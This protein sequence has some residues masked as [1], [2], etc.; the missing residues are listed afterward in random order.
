[1]T[2]TADTRI[3]SAA[4]FHKQGYVRPHAKPFTI[5]STDREIHLAAREN[6]NWLPGFGTHRGELRE[7]TK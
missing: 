4:D 5:E 6:F 7:G 3:T 2:I 1:M